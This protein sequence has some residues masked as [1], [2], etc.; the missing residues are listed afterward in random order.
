MENEIWKPVE[1]YEGLYEVSN[2]GRIKSLERTVW[3]KGRGYY[4]TVP[5]RI[6]KP[7]NNGQGYLFVNLCK[8]GKMKNCRVH[9][10]VGQAFIP[11]PNN[12][13]QINHKDENK[14]NNMVE[15]L[16]WCSSKYNNNYGTHNQRMAEKQRNDPKRSK[17]VIAIDK[18]TGLTVK[19]ASIGE[20]SRQ[21]VINQ[22]NIVSCLKGK[23]KS[24]GGYTWHYVE[25]KE[26]SNE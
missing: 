4:K 5:E 24:A 3:N 13:P 14:G 22:S 2:L 15:N 19:F 6:L 26:A 12:L 18:I 20:A 8:D 9:R 1:N 21:L 11:N 25:D 16:E 17:P 10:L 23:L 7:S